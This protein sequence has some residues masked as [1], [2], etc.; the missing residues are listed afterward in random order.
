M[1]RQNRSV[2]S[3]Q[4]SDET[5]RSNPAELALLSPIN[6]RDFHGPKFQNEIFLYEITQMEEFD[7][8]FA[9]QYRKDIQSF[10]GL[11]EPLT[12]MT[13]KL[14]VREDSFFLQDEIDICDEIHD[15]VRADL[16]DIATKSSLWL[17]EFFLPL[18]DVHVS[19]PERF[20]TLLEAWMIDPCIERRAN[21]EQA[22][23]L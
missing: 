2:R 14:N 18:P 15:A 4:L 17:R 22:S 3:G 23:R 21:A 6:P 10:L 11:S 1:G 12:P 7:D 9:L 5:D 13:E 16:M 20:H 19:S 8:E